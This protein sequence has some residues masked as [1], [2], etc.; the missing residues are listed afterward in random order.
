M[1][2]PFGVSV[3]DFI[4]GLKLFK[5]VIESLSDV[6]GARADYI[7]LT[8]TLS[9]L[10]TALDAAKQF[11]TV[12]HQAAIEIVLRECHSEEAED[13]TEESTMGIMQ[14]ED[15]LRFKGHLETHLGALQ[16]L[17]LTFQI[18]A[19]S[20]I[21][22][23][24]NES[25][26]GV[27]SIAIQ[28]KGYA[29]SQQKLEEET[30]NAHHTQRQIATDMK[31]LLQ[32]S[33]QVVTTQS[34]QL[35]EIRQHL[36]QG[37]SPDEQRTMFRMLEEALAERRSFEHRIELLSMQN[38][39]QVELLTTQNRVLETHLIELKA[40]VQEQ[41]EI[42][43]QVLLRRPV[44]LIDAFEEN[45][46]PFHLEFINSFEAL[47]AV[48]MIR[49]KDK[50]EG[51]IDR[52][53]RQ[54]FDMFEQSKQRRVNLSGPW[55]N[56]FLPGQFVEMSML[57][58]VS[59]DISRSRCPGCNHEEAIRLKEDEKV[60]CTACPM[61]YRW[62]RR[63][64]ELLKPLISETVRL[65]KKPEDKDISSFCRVDI[66]EL[67]E[68]GEK[69]VWWCCECGDGP[70]APE[71]SVLL[72]GLDN[73]GKTTLLEQ[74]KGTYTPSHPNLKT[75]PTVGQNVAT[76]A[77]PPPNPPIY[78][79]IWDVGGQHS[80]RGLWQSY[81]S[82]CHAIVFVIDSSDVGN[83]T[84]ADLSAHDAAHNEDIG[85]LDECKLVLESVLANEDA[86]GVPILI[87]A[88]KQDREDCVEVVRIKE[89]FVR[90]VFEGEKGG[91]VRDSRVL[92]CSA[93]TG[94]GV[95]EAVEWLC[96]RMAFNKEARPPV[97]R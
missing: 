23:V 89:G 52:I 20:Q 17:L 9:A 64:A 4:A 33:N 31:T 51:A 69:R 73:A 95:Q 14:K 15:V 45:R 19:Q 70:Y 43:P 58:P 71:Y 3:G 28:M 82:S 2:I 1:V 94:T 12:I 86:S 77:L 38:R 72:L 24:V 36:Q 11:D 10:D 76:I 79:K 65:G 90:R 44:I 56:A 62:S 68:S 42:P 7:E 66:L 93:L 21:S 54:L 85:R 27:D 25:K 84:L 59:P 29:L 96:S 40:A 6:R 81:Y 30:T 97:M 63:S 92:P 48:F 83:A 47:F 57:V 26:E 39:N 87:L 18:N 80:L 88:N 60:K 78:L 41:R 53:R 5:N 46:L 34:S 8:Q 32:S 91:N 49:F 50:G 16:L 67:P 13:W 74:I 61:T 37:L 22:K 35:S 75:V 55:A